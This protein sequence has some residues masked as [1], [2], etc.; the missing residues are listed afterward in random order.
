M[1]KVCVFLASFVTD[2]RQWKKI[3]IVAL[4]FLSI[5]K[6]CHFTFL[7][8]F[9]S[10]ILLKTYPHSILQYHRFHLRLH[11]VLYVLATFYFTL[12]SHQIM[13]SFTEKYHILKCVQ[14]S[15]TNALL[16]NNPTW[17]DKLQ[18]THKESCSQQQNLKFHWDAPWGN[19]TLLTAC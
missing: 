13:W 7:T 8:I 2:N 4:F 11:S 3:F 1:L 19:S 16:V 15:T 12:I 14:Y 17:P 10:D 18:Q 9:N 5:L 6:E